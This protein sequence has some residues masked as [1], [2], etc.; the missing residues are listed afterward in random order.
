MKLLS[1]L[2]RISL[3][4][5]A[6]ISIVLL[7]V[8]IPYNLFPIEA[9]LGLLSIFITKFILVSAAV[10]H[11]HITRKLLFPYIDFKQETNL[12]NNIMIITWYAMII[13]AFSRGG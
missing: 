2:K 1:N 10:I 5:I 12:S 6:V 13:F 8:F 4:I 3:D 9:K 7:V 11:A